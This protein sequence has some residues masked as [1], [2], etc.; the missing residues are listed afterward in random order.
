M[1]EEQKK[2]DFLT[3]E[4]A[5]RQLESLGYTN[6]KFAPKHAHY[7]QALWTIAQSP[8]GGSVS[9]LISNLQSQDPRHRRALREFSKIKDTIT[10][11][12]IKIYKKY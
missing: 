9:E 4:E 12:N 5:A 8:E 3:P 11:K 10:D 7:L 6:I 1:E 2:G